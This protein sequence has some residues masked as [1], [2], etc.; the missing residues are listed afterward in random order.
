MDGEIS[1]WKKYRTLFLFLTILVVVFI[2]AYAF[3]SELLPFLVGL[4]LAYLLLPVIKW[5]ELRIPP[6][7]KWMGAKR[8]FLIILIFLLA[9]ALLFGGIIYVYYGVKDSVLNI[10]NNS[11][12][13]IVNAQH[14]IEQWSESF[15]E[16]MP[17]AYQQQIN[18]VFDNIGSKAGEALQAI[19]KTGI[20]FIPG[21]VGM[22]AGFLALPFFLFFLLKDSE[23]LGKGFYALLPDALAVHAKNIFKIIENVIGKYIRAQLVLGSAVAILIFT[24]LSIL[25]IKLA[26]ALAVFAG[27]MELIPTVGPWIGA[28][29]GLLVI[30]AVDP[31]KVFLAA[32]VYLSANLLENLLLVPRIQGGFLRI[33]PAILMVVLVLG[34]STGGVWGMVLA[35]PLTALIVAIYKYVRS[36]P[37]STEAVQVDN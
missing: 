37:E 31:G 5:A 11:P 23:S 10:I 30:L 2:L 12:Q 8:I 6:K 27:L 24:G 9:I 7:D 14:N 35:A 20:G 4:V 25:G 36:N 13:Y 18:T 16:A 17:P 3:R 29:V 33:N 32:I 34:A 21:T 19:F 22:I 15:M 28:I 1:F 26:P